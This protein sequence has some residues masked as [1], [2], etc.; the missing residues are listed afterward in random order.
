MGLFPLALLQLRHHPNFWRSLAC[1]GFLLGATAQIIV[2]TDV[3][4]V[5]VYGFPVI[6]AACCWEVEWI[7]R[8]ARWAAWLPWLVIWAIEAPVWG[9][10]ALPVVAAPDALP[11]R[12]HLSIY[13][14]PGLVHLALACALLSLLI[15]GGLLWSLGLQARTGLHT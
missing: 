11:I 5:V 1:S 8:A 3:E 14:Q 7:A 12:L 10:Y 6:I 13:A 9:L 15:L 4:R 2:S